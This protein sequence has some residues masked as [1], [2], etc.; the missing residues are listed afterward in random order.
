MDEPF[1]HRHVS[2]VRHGGVVAPEPRRVVP[3]VGAPGV[4]LGLGVLGVVPG[5]AV[6]GA[7]PGVVALDVVP[8]AALPGAAVSV[9][10]SG[11][12]VVVPCGGPASGA[13]IGGILVVLAGSAGLAGLLGLA[14]VAVAPGAWPPGAWPTLPDSPASSWGSYHWRSARSARTDCG[15][16]SKLAPAWFPSMSSARTRLVPRSAP[17]PVPIGQPRA[18]RPPQP[19]ARTA[20]FTPLTKCSW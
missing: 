12:V 6:L 11:L 13:L 3:G 7:E 8:G 17:L 16:R 14:G 20:W 10:V 5:V 9:V 18:R 1:A 15:H 19:V 4:V 2:A